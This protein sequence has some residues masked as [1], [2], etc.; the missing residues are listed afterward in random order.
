M[1]VWRI[2]LRERALR[3]FRGE[4]ARLYG[5]RWNLPGLAIVYCAESMAL[6]C[7][8]VLVH[9]DPEDLPNELAAVSCEIPNTVRIL[10]LEASELPVDWREYPAP[11][12]LRSIGQQWFQRKQFSVLS[13]PSAVIPAERNYLLNPLHPDFG[14]VVIRQPEPFSLDPRLWRARR[15]TT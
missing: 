10:R 8:E 12:S 2:C 1:V 15:S 14:K 3:A 4:G 6:A 5:G 11:E 13:V 7:L 9:V